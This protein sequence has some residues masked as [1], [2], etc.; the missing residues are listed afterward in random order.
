M[1]KAIKSFE[2]TLAEQMQNPEFRAEFLQAQVLVK[3]QLL[4]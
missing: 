2:E 3:A 4:L 1:A